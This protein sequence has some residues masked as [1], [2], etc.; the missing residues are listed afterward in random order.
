MKSTSQIHNSCS[1][2]YTKLKFNM[3]TTIILF[4]FLH[5][6]C[7]ISSAQ[8][9]FIPHRVTY[10]SDPVQSTLSDIDGD[11][12]LDIL[13]AYTEDNLIAWHSNDGNGYF[14][15]LHIIDDSTDDHLCALLSVDI[16]NDGHIDVVSGG[17]QSINLYMN[18]GNG[19]FGSPQIISSNVQYV[20]GVFAIDLD[21]DSIIDI[22]SSS[23]GDDKIAWY[24]NLGNGS[25]GTQQI[26]N[27]SALGAYGVWAADLDSDSLVDVLSA[28]YTGDQ[29][30]WYKNLG[31]GSFGTQQ[32][33][34]DSADNAK[35]VMAADIDNDGLPDVISSQKH[36]LTWFKNLGSGSFTSEIMLNNSEW[37]GC[38]FPSDFDNDLDLD[39]VY[40][41][42]TTSINDSLIWQEN[43]GG[44]IFGPAQ[45]ISNTVDDPLGIFT[46]DVDGDGYADIVAGARTACSIEVYNNRENGFDLN[47]SIS[48]ATAHAWYLY[49][50]DLDSDGHLDILSASEVDNKIA[51]YKNL[52][53]KEFSLQKVMSESRMK[54]RSVASADLD[55]DGLKDVISGAYEDTLAWQKNLG[56]GNFGPLQKL[57]GAYNSKYIQAEDLDNDGLIDIVTSSGWSVLSYRNIGSG[58]FVLWNTIINLT[59]LIDFE[60]EDLNNDGYMD[61][62]CGTSISVVLSL[63]DGTGNFSPPQFITTNGVSA[64]CLDDINHDG[65]NDIVCSGNEGGISNKV[66]KWY[67]NDGLGNFSTVN[68]ISVLPASSYTICTTDINNDSLT[69]IITATANSVEVL[70]WFE[71][72]GNGNIGPPQVID[73]LSGNLYC[74][75]PADFD[76]DNDND[77]SIAFYGSSSVKWLENTRNNLIETIVI[78]AGDS[79]L[80]MGNWENQPGDYMDSLVNIA[81]GDSIVIVRLENYPTYYPVDTVEICEGDFYD[82]NGQILTTAGVYYSTF[83]SSHGCDSIVELP[84]T[85]IQAPLVN[86][87]EFNPDSTNINGGIVDLPAASPPGG[88]YSGTGVTNNVFDPSISGTGEIWISYSYTDTFTGCSNKDSTYINVYDPVGIAELLNNEVKLYPNPGK[89][90]FI[91]DIGNTAKTT[92]LQLFD[93]QGKHVIQREIKERTSSI[94][95]SNLSVGVYTYVVKEQGEIIAIGKWVKQ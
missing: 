57:L 78:C 10:G 81:G 32:I 95:T 58:D 37:P 50:D 61:F 38:F 49:A 4:I 93:G 3:K 20:C 86:I 46:G 68:V 1:N 22:A 74:I 34:S 28:S 7:N 65:F 33:L 42:Y 2:F 54:A 18:L 45:F 77:L 92:E 84:L 19:I 40:T 88:E 14:D 66:V 53:N 48:Y 79:A 82:F 31:N 17:G 9:I 36:K 59:G 24:K 73:S 80:I 13:A 67:P 25:F 47:Q 21:N 43:L 71:N 41:T 27:S 39:L 8:S 87:S 11:N 90:S 52:N 29:I 75:Y 15:S 6:I 72:L 55:N 76:N 56:G 62:V 64:L 60:L 91:L 23:F 89:G 44:G 94:N 12:D 63:N 70:Y 30:A 5:L 85:L 69:D 83:Q 16:D 51:W 35:F 26:I